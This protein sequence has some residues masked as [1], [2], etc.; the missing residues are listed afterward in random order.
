[1]PKVPID[2]QNTIIYQLKCNDDNITEV[3][4]GSTTNFLKRRQTH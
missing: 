4:V 1:M 3:Y 2:Y